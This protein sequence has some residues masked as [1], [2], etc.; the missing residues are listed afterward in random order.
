M[1]FF[2]YYNR[3]VFFSEINRIVFVTNSDTDKGPMAV[4]ALSNSA[5]TKPYEIE[6]RGL[7]VL[8]P[9][10]MNEKAEAV[11]IS[12]GVA[13]K[14]FHSAAISED[15]FTEDTL[16]IALARDIYESLLSKFPEHTSTICLLEDIIE[17]PVSYENLHGL[18]LPAYGQC[19][20]K[21]IKDMGQL[22]SYF[23]ERLKYY[24]R[25]EKI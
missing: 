21:M 5:L 13:K 3:V 8:F 6:S 25:D 18:E 1:F 10:P 17:S 20:E 9:E 2:F 12:N 14:D 23:N 15:D 22:A 24:E 16:I 4:A 19:Y 7:V 11:L